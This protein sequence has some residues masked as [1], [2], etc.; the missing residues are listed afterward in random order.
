MDNMSDPTDIA[1]TRLP[2]ALNGVAEDERS[3]GLPPLKLGEQGLTL[4]PHAGFLVPW[5]AR[6]AAAV[7]QH[8]T[9]KHSNSDT[10]EVN[11]NYHSRRG[12]RKIAVLDAIPQHLWK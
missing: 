7:D 10:K 9:F 11:K 5:F 1:F 4:S 8:L 2:A 6:R 12:K 3:K